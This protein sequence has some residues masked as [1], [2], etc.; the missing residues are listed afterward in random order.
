MAK[1]QDASNAQ[2][3]VRIPTW[4]LLPAVLTVLAAL[5]DQLEFISFLARVVRTWRELWHEGF[6]RLFAWAG[7]YVFIPYTER[8]FQILTLWI[9]LLGTT[10]I[11]TLIVVYFR[12]AGP[13]RVV[14]LFSFL[15]RPIPT[16]AM[17]IV[18]L[19]SFALLTYPFQW[20]ATI[21]RPP[22][23]G[24]TPANA[25]QL[26]WLSPFVFGYAALFFTAMARGLLSPI[27]KGDTVLNVLALIVALTPLWFP[28]FGNRDEIAVLVALGF[29]VGGT[30]ALSSLS[31]ALPM[32]QL[33]GLCVSVLALDWICRQLLAIWTAVNG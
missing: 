3:Y 19:L 31:S 30:I 25:A 17:A 9:T 2:R 22:F 23:A 12:K 7:H 20:A 32:V 10:G 6:A 33:A 24:E 1:D 14:D 26:P 21:I 13:Q 18:V 15:P 4:V 16:L 11:G 28:L 27:P 5:N 29:G 8:E